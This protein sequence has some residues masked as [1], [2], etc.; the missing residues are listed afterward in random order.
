MNLHIRVLPHWLLVVV[1]SGALNVSAIVVE[2][3]IPPS[4]VTASSTFSAA[5]D[6]KHLVDGSGLS[7]DRHDNDSGAK[8]MWHSVEKPATSSPGAGLPAVP[9]WVRFDF[10]PA[11]RVR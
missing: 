2:D 10:A 7:G 11:A 8:T 9:A 5:Q 3:E 1:L 6:A 4:K